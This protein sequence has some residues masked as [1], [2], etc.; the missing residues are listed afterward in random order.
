M[1]VAFMSRRFN[2][3]LL[4]FDTLRSDYLTCYRPCSSDSSGF[5][6]A[7]NEG[8][9]FKSAFGT[10]PGTPISHAS[11][12]TG[13][14]PSEHGVTGQYTPLPED[15]PV[16]AEWFR[17]AGYETFGVTGPA[18]MGSDWR[19]DR[20][21]QEFF[22]PYYDLPSP[23][24][25]GNVRKSL[26]DR[27][28]R[29]YFIRQLTKGGHDRTRF[30]FELL[31]DRITSDLHRPFLAMANFTTVHAPYDPPRPYKRNAT[32]EFSRPRLFL[33]EH[34]LGE[35]GRINDPEIRTDRIMNIQSGDG[36]GR[37]IANS[38]YLNEEEIKFIR[39]WYGAAVKYLDDE[40]SRFLEFYRQELQED[41]IL[42]LT[43]DHGEQLGEHGLWG[44]SYGF[45]DETLQIPLIVIGPSLPK[46]VRREGMISHIDIFDTLCDLC[47]LERPEETSGKSVFSEGTRSAV[48]MEYGE[49]DADEFA[50]NSSHGRHLDQ[51][52]LRELAAGRKAIRT[53]RYRL[54][55]CSNGTERLFKVSDQTRVS[56]LPENLTGELRK[57]IF[58]TLGDDFGRWPETDSKNIE[59]DARAKDN[60]RDLGYIE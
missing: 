57:R 41:T 42:M 54:E 2:V 21:F 59:I 8:V 22:E 7:A 32:P 5:E 10:A 23:T 46:G 58:E 25:L 48:F 43:A 15:V 53:D 29:R 36:I 13:M 30:K 33:T 17:E 12:F 24:S 38:N 34:L 37:Y 9:L 52:R 14:Y 4:I 11:I 49:R 39:K 60:L 31:K 51:S 19:Y 35:H 47:G 1:F 18:K 20:G 27:R 45:Y 3:I 56:E 55:V 40:V 50:T 26:I 44:H 6:A 16:M 28:F